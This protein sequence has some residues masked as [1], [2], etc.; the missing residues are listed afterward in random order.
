MI[1]YCIE[2]VPFYSVKT[3]LLSLILTIPPSI[4][5]HNGI[6]IASGSIL[7]AAINPCYGLVDGEVFEK[8][9]KES[10]LLPMKTTPVM[11][12]GSGSKKPYVRIVG[13]S[14]LGIVYVLYPHP[15]MSAKNGLVYD[16]D[17]D[18]KY[19]YTIDNDGRR[20]LIDLFAPGSVSEFVCNK[21]NSLGYPL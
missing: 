21:F 7:N 1:Y 17:C 16:V 9:I 18:R 20:N 3:L 12:G 8:C 14:S 6:Q 10:K 19:V 11:F 15:I 13:R 5:S 2:V 4:D